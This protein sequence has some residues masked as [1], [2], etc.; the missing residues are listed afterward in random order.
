MIRRSSHHAM[1]G[2]VCSGYAISE[3]KPVALVRTF[4]AL[5]LLCTGG[6]AAFLYVLAWFFMPKTK[7]GESDAWDK[8]SVEDKLLV[9]KKTNRVIAGV[10]GALA[11]HFK[12]DASVVRALAALSFLVGGAGLVAYVFAWAIIPEE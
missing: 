9:R 2:G 3:N 4:A 6:A 8:L 5:T 11:D 10:C 12:V 7:A 1:I